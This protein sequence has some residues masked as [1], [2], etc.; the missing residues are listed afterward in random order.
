M[1][2]EPSKEEQAKQSAERIEKS[3]RE[4]G[5]KADGLRAF[6]EAIAREIWRL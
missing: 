4:A 2:P 6:C 5:F 1:K 3:F